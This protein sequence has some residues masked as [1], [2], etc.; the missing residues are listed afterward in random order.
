[1]WFHVIL[2]LDL[3]DSGEAGRVGLVGPA[4]SAHFLR[5]PLELSPPDPA[6]WWRGRLL[7]PYCLVRRHDVQRDPYHPRTIWSHWSLCL[8]PIQSLHVKSLF[9]LPFTHTTFQEQEKPQRHKHLYGCRLHSAY[10]VP[11]SGVQRLAHD[12]NTIIGYGVLLQHILILSYEIP[13]WRTIN[14]IAK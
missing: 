8:G 5:Q 3:H 10:H 2:S 11:G 14:R 12:S 9:S 6:A 7:S 4:A 1:M 13:I